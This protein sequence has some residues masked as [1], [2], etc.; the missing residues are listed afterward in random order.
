MAVNRVSVGSDGT[1]ANGSSSNPIISPD[2]TKVVFESDATNLTPNDTNGQRDI[3]LKDLVNNQISRLSVSANGD[4]ANGLSSN[5]SFSPDGTKVTFTS[6]ANNLVPGDTNGAFDSF[7]KDIA[8]GSIT[9]VSLSSS[10]VQSSGGDSGTP[11]LSPDGTMAIFQ[12][13]ARFLPQDNNTANDI[14]LKN[15]TTNATTLV[16]SSSDGVPNNGTQTYRPSFAENGSKV[17]FL[18]NASNLVPNDTNN[19]IDLFIKDLQSNNI[20]RVSTA[21]D[22]S[23]IAGATNQYAISPDGSKVA[24]TSGATNLVPNDTNGRGDVFLKELSSGVVT[25]I[26]TNSD[27]SQLNNTSTNPVFSAD[28]K[29]LA[30]ETIASNVLPN[31]SAPG[32]GVVTKN[33]STGETTF[34]SRSVDGSTGESGINPSL[35]ADGSKIAFQSFSTNLTTGDTNGVSDVFVADQVVCFATGTRIRMSDGE[36]AVED[37][38]EGDVVVTAEGTRRPIT[39]IGHRH[40]NIARHPNP[41]AVWPVRVLANAFGNG[42]PQCDL[43]LSPD[44]AVCVR[45]LD[46]VLIPIKHLINDATVARVKTEAVTYWHVELDAHDILLAEGMPVESFLDTGVRHFFANADGFTSLHP[47]FHPLT[48]SDFCRPLVQ[49]GPIVDAVRM[50]L[51]ARAEH[52]GWSL[53][54]EDDLHVLADGVRLDP[55]RVSN[56]ARF[57]LPATAK[58]VRLVSRSFVPERVRVGAGDGRRLGIPVRG[59]SVLDAC[60]VTRVLPIDHPLFVD[61]FSFVQW[62]EAEAWRWTDGDAALPAVLWEGATG[63][64]VLSIE[65]APEHGQMKAWLAPTSTIEVDL[66]QDTSLPRVA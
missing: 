2:G 6:I 37:L 59:I 23:Q 58:D 55:Q 48:L 12:S 25:R 17:A 4:Q 18:S 49:D 42:L 29:Y 53:T 15:L 47:D 43:Y 41:E 24:F 50:R 20:T 31:N 64:V 10:G 30:F 62:H 40:V 13:N 36:V 54:S 57:I 21:S 63:E 60:G 7:V 11:V 5:A 66:T 52:L 33:L 9:R 19:N 16:S 45:V 46:E 32:G 35:S 28:G 1:Q 38:R 8:T 26:S 22:G 61:G 34:V 51:L 65:T 56:T 27:G 14:Y 44:H 39:W 3:F